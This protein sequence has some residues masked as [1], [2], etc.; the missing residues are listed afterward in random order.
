[1]AK[2][3]WRHEF[4]ASELTEE[5]VKSVAESGKAYV[6]DHLDVYGRPVMIGTLS[7]H[8]PGVSL[9]YELPII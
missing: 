5:S 7:K 2:Q 8:I 3:R 1:M 9:Q 4:G 6:H